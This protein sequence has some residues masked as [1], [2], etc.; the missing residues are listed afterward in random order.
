M[1]Q[2]IVIA[3]GGYLPK[4]IL[5]NKD[6]EKIV[7]TT[8]DW[9][10]TRTGIKQR[11]IAADDELTSDMAASAAKEALTNASL[12]PS[13]IDLII[14][15]TTTPDSTFPSTA[16]KVQHK[17]GIKTCIAFD[18]QAVC[19]GFVYATSI[20]DN[21]IKAKQVKNALIIGAEKMSSIID[22]KD[23]RTCVLFGDGAGAAILSSSN[24]TNRGVLSTHLYADGKYQDI[25]YT[26]GGV[27]S[28]QQAGK[29]RMNGQEVFKHAVEKM[30][31]AIVD[32]LKENEYSLEDIDIL[33]PHQA[34]IRILD[35]VA[36]KL[37]LPSEKIIRTVD[38]HANTSAASIPLA[39]SVALNENRIKPKDIVVFEAIGGGLTWGTCIIK[40]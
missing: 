14:V 12:K 17:L 27:A 31:S 5:S 29:I 4:E 25:L 16:V 15:A 24:D 11:H 8:D 20:A 32:G 26:D 9:I 35:M 13:D 33:I 39:L 21:F 40:W 28:S 22:W 23:R 38:K 7:D 30:T 3:G 34:N 10:T 1:A 2:S 6:L 19:S 37:K 18:I 36:K